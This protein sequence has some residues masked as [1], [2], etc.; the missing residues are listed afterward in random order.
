[1]E[2]PVVHVSW[3]EADAY[4]RWSGKRL[5]TEAGWEKAAS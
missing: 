3:Y 4:A 5:P 2:A 1:M